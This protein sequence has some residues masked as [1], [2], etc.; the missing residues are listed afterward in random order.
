M[1]LVTCDRVTSTW[2]RAAVHLRSLTFISILAV[3]VA[4]TNAQVS[5]ELAVADIASHAAAA[6]LID[7]KG[8]ATPRKA[9]VVD[10]AET[11]GSPTALGQQ[12]AGEFSTFLE[13][14]AHGSFVVDRGESLRE[15]AEE[16][17][18]S[19]S[20]ESSNVTM[21]YRDEV[22]AAVV[23]EGIIDDLSDRIALRVKVWRIADRKNIF[24]E[25]ILLPVTEEMRTLHAKAPSNPNIPPLTGDEIWINYEQ[26][27]SNH[28]VPTAGTKGFSFPACLRCPNVDYTY[29]AKNAKIQGTVTLSVVIGSD[30]S[31]EKI[32]VIK[33]LPCG[34]TRQA[35]DSVAHWGF[36]PATDAEGKPAEVQET[37]EVSFYLY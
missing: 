20:F 18:F 29:A 7:S 35:M 17:L 19:E 14:Q 26:M 27:P 34:L 24:D 2:L 10:F 30:G 23:V 3:F 15:T 36:K 33:G 31:A 5:N 1:S 13:K 8:L 4:G 37:V 9:L 11:H 21:C 28:G 22:G 12:L 16:R 6:I 32:S 25:R